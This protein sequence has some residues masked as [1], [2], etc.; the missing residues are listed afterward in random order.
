MKLVLLSDVHGDWTKAMPAI[1]LANKLGCNCVSLGDLGDSRTYRKTLGLYDNFYLVAGN[2]E[3]YP[4]L[5][6]YTNYLGDFGTLPFASNV[7]FVRGAYSID[8]NYRTPG[9]DWFPD[10]ELTYTKA[11]Q[12]LELYE[13]LKPEIVLTHD[14]PYY[15]A[16]KIQGSIIE[17]FTG[18]MLTEMIKIYEPRNWYH[19][20]HHRNLVWDYGNTTLHS[21]AINEFLEIEV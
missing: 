10:E 13:E 9:Y 20:H 11:E 5:H 17:S 21:L 18:R 19:G 3:E 4:N 6:N 1:T 8:K 12:A 14:C 15:M 16:H 7:F 2:H